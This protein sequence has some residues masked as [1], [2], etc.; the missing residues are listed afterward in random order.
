M[1]GAGHLQLPFQKLLQKT[2]CP[3]ELTLATLCL[4]NTHS[5]YSSKIKKYSRIFKKRNCV[6][7]L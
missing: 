2:N 4:T 1:R 5:S 6:K 3:L 7:T